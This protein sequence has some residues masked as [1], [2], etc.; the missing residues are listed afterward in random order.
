METPLTEKGDQIEKYTT[1]SILVTDKDYQA[2]LDALMQPHKSKLIVVD[3]FEICFTK[4][5][6][7]WWWRLW[8]KIFFGFKWEKMNLK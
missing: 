5:I 8:H 7:N 6:P 2:N 4:S 1:E 3:G